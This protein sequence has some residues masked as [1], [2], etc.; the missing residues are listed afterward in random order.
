MNDIQMEQ[1]RQLSTEGYGYTKI[2]RMLSLPGNTVKSFCRRK[3]L[4]RGSLATGNKPGQSFCK[5][6][7]KELPINN[8][9]KKF[10]SAACRRSYWK[11]NQDKINRRSMVT[12]ICPVCHREYRYYK[13]KEQK[14]CSH[15][16]Y[17]AARYTSNK[18]GQLA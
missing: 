12:R 5:M 13:K 18:N 14:Y 3:R 7:G 8:R 1:I 10:C 15:A 11:E 6:C 9:H 17:I 16:C 4:V 2:A